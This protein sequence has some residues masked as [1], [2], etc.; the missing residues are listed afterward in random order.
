MDNRPEELNVSKPVIDIPARSPSRLGLR[1]PSLKR[2]LSSHLLLNGHPEVDRNTY[3]RVTPSDQ[4]PP[5]LFPETCSGSV[6]LISGDSDSSDDEEDCVSLTSHIIS[7]DAQPL[8]LDTGSLSTELDIQNDLSSRPSAS[9]SDFL[10]SVSSI[11]DHG[12]SHSALKLLKKMWNIRQDE[13]ELWKC[14]LDA[15]TSAATVY[16]A[17]VET[18]AD[19][20]TGTC[21]SIDSSIPHSLPSLS[22]PPNISSPLP[23]LL[24]LQGLTD[25]SA[26]LDVPI[27]PR[28]GDL[29]RCRESMCAPLDRVFCSTPIH[30]IRKAFYFS[31]MVR[32]HGRA[33]LDSEIKS[34]EPCHDS[35]PQDTPD[36]DNE[37]EDDEDNT[38]LVESESSP[39]LFSKID[40][41]SVDIHSKSTQKYWLDVQL[42]VVRYA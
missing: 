4:E 20:A 5:S 38:T 15:S 17:I 32:G 28:F 14:Q 40:A 29:S 12:L 27:F 37:D 31:D 42:D 3:E 1:P 21:T 35:V 18:P 30:T 39:Y 9:C 2:A 26:P 8:N 16:D 22:F 13:W 19:P 34:V 6:S 11:Q 7:D 23:P 25:T 41:S 24:P 33:D 10:F 36:I